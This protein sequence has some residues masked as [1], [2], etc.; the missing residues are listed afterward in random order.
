[1]KVIKIIGA[2][3]KPNLYNKT[4]PLNA[5]YKCGGVY[6]V[7]KGDVEFNVW[8]NVYEAFKKGLEELKIKFIE[9]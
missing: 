5:Y 2:E 4:L 8:D 9:K 7:T 1:M 6:N 3:N